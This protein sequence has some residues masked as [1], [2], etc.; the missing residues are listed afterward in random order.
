MPRNP[1]HRARK[2]TP[3]G[4][5]TKQAK[6]KRRP[7]PSG[8]VASVKLARVRLEQAH[9]A[10]IRAGM[11]AEAN[12]VRVIL[13]QVLGP[14]VPSDICG[15]S[16]LLGFRAEMCRLASLPSHIPSR[17]SKK[18]KPRQMTASTTTSGVKEHRE[19]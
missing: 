13:R 2:R 11:P 7:A 8:R 9:R 12:A 1:S 17:Q 10:L 3:T 4:G 5:V 16:M 15:D 18:K 6:V 14:R 19:D